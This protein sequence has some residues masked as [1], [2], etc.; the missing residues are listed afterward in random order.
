MCNQS[1]KKGQRYNISGQ[2]SIRKFFLNIF[3][4]REYVLGLAVSDEKVV[5]SRF[6]FLLALKYIKVGGRDLTAQIYF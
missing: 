5:L 4:F 2:V 1:D 3:I 6:P